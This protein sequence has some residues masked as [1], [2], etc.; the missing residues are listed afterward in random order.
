MALGG[1]KFAGYKCSRGTTTDLQWVLLC[2][3]IR[4][5]AFIESSTLSNAGWA[6]DSDFTSGMYAFESSGNVIYSMDNLG[7]NLVSFFKHG[8]GDAYFAILTLG[9]YQATANL[10]A[11]CVTIDTPDVNGSSHYRIGN[12]CT[13]FCKIAKTQITPSDVLG[14]VNGELYMM[15]VGRLLQA[16]NY[17]NGPTP[18]TWESSGYTYLGL[19]GSVYAGFATKG[20][21]IISFMGYSESG[22]CICCFSSSAFSS[23]FNNGDLYTQFALNPMQATSGSATNERNNVFSTGSLSSQFGVY[24]LDNSGSYVANPLLDSSGKSYYKASESSQYRSFDSLSV[25]GVWNSTYNNSAKGTVYI[26]FIAYN[27]CDTL[28]SLPAPYRIVANG[29]YMC[30]SNFTSSSG[31]TQ[32]PLNGIYT[33]S[34][35]PKYF[36]V[37]YVG[38]DP[39]NPDIT[40]QSAWTEY[41]GA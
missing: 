13:M 28:A 38:W 9:Y 3:K 7:Y 10:A 5:K 32:E 36:P 12:G 15:P 34:S 41:T 40:Q 2:H 16:A 20:V 27:Y 22:L 21:K 25:S 1:Y 24:A 29:N 6:F 17:N 14:R 4:V 18:S 35:G 30:A 19:G 33:T 23:L 37:L 8:T 11:G 26:D 31:L 39:S